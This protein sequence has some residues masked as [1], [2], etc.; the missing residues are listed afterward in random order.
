MNRTATW[1]VLSLGAA[2]T[3]LGVA[4][5][6]AA[7]ADVGPVV[8]APHPASVNVQLSA[9]VPYLE[10]P[11]QLNIPQEFHGLYDSADSGSWWDS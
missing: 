5:A 4:G 9:D 1:M 3:G 11:M 7:H 2:L 6:G 8:A 10:G